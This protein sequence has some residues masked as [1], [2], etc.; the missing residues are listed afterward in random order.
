M[1]MQRNVVHNTALSSAC[2]KRGC[3]TIFELYGLKVTYPFIQSTHP[4]LNQNSYITRLQS[5]RHVVVLL[6]L[7]I[8]YL[9]Q[10]RYQIVTV[11]LTPRFFSPFL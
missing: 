10:F 9:F 11:I 6:L 3:F 4:F 7:L 2:S 1:H 8:S 5:L